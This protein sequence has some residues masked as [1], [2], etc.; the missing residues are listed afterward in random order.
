MPNENAERLTE[1]KD[2]IKALMDEA[3]QIVRRA[4]H[5]TYEQARAYWYPHLIMAL[6]KE[7]G[8]L[9]GSMFTMQDAIDALKHED[10]E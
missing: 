9:G 2:E 5:M 10:D 3:L 7:H 1:I 4:D 8:Y 6:D